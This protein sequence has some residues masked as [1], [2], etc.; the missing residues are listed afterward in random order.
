MSEID[1]G[2]ADNVK[3]GAIASVTVRSSNCEWL[4]LPLVPI[5]V[6]E[7]MALGVPGSTVIVAVEVAVLPAG[8]VT[9]DGENAT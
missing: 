4:R 8:G 7:V 2:L 3:S 1:G 5:I 9:L 6:S